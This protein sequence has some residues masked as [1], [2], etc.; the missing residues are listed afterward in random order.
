VNQAQGAS[1]RINSLPYPEVSSCLRVVSIKHGH[2]K[3][4]CKRRLDVLLLFNHVPRPFTTSDEKY[5]KTFSREAVSRN[6][7]RM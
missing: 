6:L 7:Y 1:S 4:H 5:L 2:R 3:V